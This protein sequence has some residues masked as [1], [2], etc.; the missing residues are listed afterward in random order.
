MSLKRQIQYQ[1]SN[2]IQAFLSLEIPAW[3]NSK[4]IKMILIVIIVFSG[5]G[6]IT[7]TASGASG[8]YEIH[9]L[10]AKV[11]NLEEE[12]SKLNVEVAEN[13]SLASISGRVEG[14]NLVPVQ[15]ISFYSHDDQQVAKR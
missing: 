3:V 13:S 15:T 10:E 14:K 4:G 7:K 2:L 1:Y 12:I 5:L 6:Y 8:G 9:S 11:Q